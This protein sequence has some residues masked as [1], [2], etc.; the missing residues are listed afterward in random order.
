MTKKSKKNQKSYGNL[1]Q[2]VGELLVALGFTMG[3]FP[4]G[5]YAVLWWV[6]PLTIANLIF[7]IMEKNGTRNYAITNVVMGL[8]AIIPVIGVV[9][10]MVG[11]FMSVLSAAKSGE[12]HFS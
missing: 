4:F 7:S 8:L 5:Y 2:M 9:P 3:L 6:I 11:I 12:R 1:F 10:R